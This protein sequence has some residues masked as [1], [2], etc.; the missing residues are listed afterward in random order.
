[1]TSVPFLPCAHQIQF[2]SPFIKEHPAA[3]GETISFLH[4]LWYLCGE[5]LRIVEVQ[6]LIW[7]SATRKV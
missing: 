7:N 5:L 3:Y 6:R 2:D 4:V 1:M